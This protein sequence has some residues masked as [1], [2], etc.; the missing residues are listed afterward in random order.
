M[1][2]MLGIKNL[3]TARLKRLRKTLRSGEKPS[4]GGKARPIF[5]DLGARVKLVRFPTFART[6]FFR[7]L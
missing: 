7:G 6:K 5:N 1:N 3:P 2:C 4:S